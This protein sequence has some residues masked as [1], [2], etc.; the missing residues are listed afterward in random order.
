MES[1]KLN[2]AE[3]RTLWR[4]ENQGDNYKACISNLNASHSE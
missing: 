2:P 1:M 4:L 3:M